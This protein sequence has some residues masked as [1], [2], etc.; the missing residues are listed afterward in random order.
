MAGIVPT[1]AFRV[2]VSNFSSVP[3]RLVKDMNI[4]TIRPLATKP[5]SQDEAESEPLLLV[6]EGSTLGEGEGN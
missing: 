3:V 6:D 5:L 4:C 2:Y 1:R